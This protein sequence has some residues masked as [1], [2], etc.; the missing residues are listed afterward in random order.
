MATRYKKFQLKIRES[1]VVNDGLTPSIG[2]ECD[3]LTKIVVAIFDL[4]GFT[5]FFDS[6][7]INKNIIVASYVNGFLSWLN[8]RLDLAQ[9]PS[10]KLSKFLGDGVLYIW[11]TEKQKITSVI[12]IALMN[13]CWNT[14]RGRDRYEK[15]FLP[16]FINQVGK[17]WDCEYQKHLRVSLATGHAVKYVQG[18]RSVEYVSECINVASHLLKI[19]PEVYFIAH[20]DLVL[21]EEPSEHNY[22]EKRIREIR[23]IDR[24]IC[25]FIDE[26]DFVSIKDKSIF[27]DI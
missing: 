3:D 20:S 23:G 18:N 6:A 27:E 11:E 21:G 4:E 14:V 2:V 25:V 13:A 8:Y 24:S 7:S 12:A 17:K 10:P 16:Q 9:L 22:V 19:H 26:D 15:E 5:N 1:R